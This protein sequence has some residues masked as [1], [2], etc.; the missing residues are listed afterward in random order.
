[1]AAGIA[2]LRILGSP[3]LYDVLEDLGSTLAGGL[4]GAARRAE[5][6][7]G[8]NRVGSMMT[9]FFTA[10]PVTDYDSA[11]HSDTGRFARFHQEMLARGVYLPPS[12]FEALFVSLSHTQPDLKATIAAAEEAFRALS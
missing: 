3:G 5:V 9:L 7:L 10:D 2:T 11:K 4:E 8:A 1:M 6:N 12:Q